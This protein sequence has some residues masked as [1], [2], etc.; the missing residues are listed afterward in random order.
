MSEE[1]HPD[2]FVH[3]AE[4]RTR[5]IRILIVVFVFFGICFYF[6]GSLMRILYFPLYQ[7]L[8]VGAHLVFLDQLGAF[9]TIT[10]VSFLAAVLLSLPWILYQVWSFV[11]P[12]LYDHE[13]KFVL[14]LV[15]LSVF[16]LGMGIAFAYWLVL[17]AAYRFFFAFSASTGVDVLQDL[18]KYS[19]FTLAMFFGFGITFEVPVV[20]ILLVKMNL[21]SIDQL[22]NS[23]RYFI[24]GAFF[25][26]AV[27]TPPDVMSQLML[28]IPLCV[29]YELGLLLSGFF[30]RIGG[31]D[32][33]T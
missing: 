11:A 29:L 2:F 18:Q 22:K 32:Q 17:P 4:L 19:D 7:V 10:R 25:V 8:P 33:K 16:F 13:K 6:S 15:F 5:L 3:L 12:G 9:F 14:P 31:E 27:I 26:G 21:V 30:Q 20:Q 28:A 24:V 1:S 23:R